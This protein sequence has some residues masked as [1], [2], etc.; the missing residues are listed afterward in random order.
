M[1]NQR[2]KFCGLKVFRNTTSRVRVTYMAVKSEIPTPR[3]RVREKP[4]TMVA[5]NAEPNQKR[6]REVMMVARFESRMDDQA[7]VQPWSTAWVRFFPLRSSSFNRSKMRMFASSAA[8][9]LSRKPAMPGRV[10]VKWNHLKTA[11]ATDA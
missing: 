1:P 7:R 10:S 5:P 3:A 11:N 4:F 6:I 8:P 9:V 2:S